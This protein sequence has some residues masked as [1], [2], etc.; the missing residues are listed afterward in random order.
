MGRRL[1][2]RLE[3][4]SRFVSGRG[5]SL[6]SRERICLDAERAPAGML[7]ASPAPETSC[8]F[9]WLFVFHFMQLEKKKIALKPGQPH[10]VVLGESRGVVEGRRV[11]LSQTVRRQGFASMQKRGVPPVRDVISSACF[12]WR[13]GALI[14]TRGRCVKTTSTFTCQLPPHP[15]TSP[16]TN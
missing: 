8:V 1:V 3:L 16:A 15:S 13:T 7:D 14:P 9:G 2:R 4:N 10:G 12:C 6:C 11:G 5:R